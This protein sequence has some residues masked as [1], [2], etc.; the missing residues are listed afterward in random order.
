MSGL[1]T[2]FR[3]GSVRDLAEYVVKFAKVTTFFLLT[4]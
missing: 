3:G 4:F 1:N 2:P